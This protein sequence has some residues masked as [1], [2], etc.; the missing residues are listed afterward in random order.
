MSHD[1]A[2]VPLTLYTAWL[3][4]CDEW[5]GKLRRYLA[6]PPLTDDESEEYERY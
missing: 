5:A 4:F 6:L 3:C 1:I 2:F